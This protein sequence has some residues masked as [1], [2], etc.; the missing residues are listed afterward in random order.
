MAATL[1]ILPDP[2]GAARSAMRHI[3]QARRRTGR[4]KAA[5]PEGFRRKSPSGSS[6]RST[7]L[8]GTLF[9]LLLP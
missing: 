5:R 3:G 9:A 6:K 1:P 7:V 8:P 4:A 2:A